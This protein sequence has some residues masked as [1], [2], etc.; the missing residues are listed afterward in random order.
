MSVC[1]AYERT[2]ADRADRMSRSTHERK[3]KTYVSTKN[4][5]VYLRHNCFSED[6][7]IVIAM[8]AMGCQSD[9]EILVLICGSDEAYQESFG[10]CLEEAAR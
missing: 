2:L 8:K 1:C 4:S 7:P 10:I 5:K 9:K 6:I 3:S